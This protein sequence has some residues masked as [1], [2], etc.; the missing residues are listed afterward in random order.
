MRQDIE[1]AMKRT[2]KMDPIYKAEIEQLTEDLDM[3]IRRTSKKMTRLE[4][5]QKFLLQNPDH[6][7]PSDV[8]DDLVLLNKTQW[9]QLS[10]DQ[11]DNIH[12]GVLTAMALND[13]KNELRVGKKKR[14]F[15]ET[16][17]AT[18]VEMPKTRKLRRGEYADLKK[19]GKILSAGDYAKNLVGIAQSRPDVVIEKLFGG[20][21]VGRDVIGRQI[22]D[23]ASADYGY[24]QEVFNDFQRS[25][26][27]KGFEVNQ[28]TS[29]WIEEEVDIKGLDLPRKLERGQRISIY[30]HTLDQ[31]NY[32]SM[33]TG[34]GFRDSKNPNTIYPIT[35]EQIQAVVD[36]MDADE[37]AWAEAARE[38][39]KKTGQD[40]QDEFFNQ[41][42]WRPTMR[43]NYMRKDTMAA[44]R[45]VGLD[46]ESEEFLEDVK[47]KNYRVG[48]DKRQLIERQDVRVPIYINNIA[49]ELN[50][51]VMRASA[52]VN[53]EAP[54]KN[55]HKL[56]T[57][58]RVRQAILKQ[59]NG[60]A[61][62]QYL[63]KY[64]RDVAGEHE[65]Y[66]DFSKGI[67][68]LRAGVTKYALGGNLW[69]ATK[70]AL[71]YPFAAMYVKPK[72]LM[73]GAVD[74]TFH[75][76]KTKGMHEQY[77]ARFVERVEGGF[78]RDIAEAMKKN[79]AA[80]RLLNDKKSFGQWI[81]KP[82]RAVDAKTVSGVMSGALRQAIDEFAE[83]KLS[84]EVQDALGSDTDLVDIQNMS[85]E[86]QLTLAYKFADYAVS[87]TQPMFSPEF[88][89]Q[90]QRGREIEKLFTQFSS[91]TNQELNMMRRALNDAKK[92]NYRKLAW[93]AAS[94]VANGAGVWA[95]D[96][97]RDIA[98]GKD[99]EDRDTLLQKYLDSTFGMYY[100]LRDIEKAVRSEYQDNIELPI[101]R[102]GEKIVS[103]ISALVDA[104]DPEAS[105][106]KRQQ[107]WGRFGESALDVLMM[108]I[109][110]PYVLKRGAETVL[111]A[112][113]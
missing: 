39:F 75:P 20:E 27:D 84:R 91:F 106:K 32:E 87:R 46:V 25:L 2:T 62:F 53:L 69:V 42:W 96:R 66:G 77:S 95:I 70:Q 90:L 4:N 7:M 22:E 72:Y 47:R 83:G 45:N 65:V 73:L 81:M 33:L 8:M 88:L 99:E 108:R 71:S 35:K 98:R 61:A 93:F 30:L 52:Y 59:R 24:R 55:A 40:Q 103:S 85:S 34:I 38:T 1:Q 17:I 60:A 12:R 109:G 50:D 44:G 16:A 58:K 63:N 21:G 28:D 31:D 13:Q 51:A 29:K 6:D 3:V 86:E 11:M 79:T 41:N 74:E 49:V 10:P 56:L 110:I 14:D 19:K 67:Q 80:R 68:K 89:S 18:V 113:K 82:T 54:L 64:L 57:D 76:R 102:I 9:G 43:D 104:F 48:V 37:K 94:F 107:A 78:S 15:E 92:G 101:S 23:G 111:E 100:G 97:A 36:S 26:I 105:P 112:V 5:T